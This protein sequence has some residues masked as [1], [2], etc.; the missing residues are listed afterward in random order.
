[1]S[2][3]TTHTLDVKIPA[4][5]GVTVFAAMSFGGTDNH[6]SAQSTVSAEECKQ[7]LAH[8][9]SVVTAAVERELA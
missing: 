2:V 5:A 6:V 3:R 1:M 7:A 4:V 9:L 8:W